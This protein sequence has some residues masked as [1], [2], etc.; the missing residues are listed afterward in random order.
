MEA[1]A[2]SPAAPPRAPGGGGMDRQDRLLKQLRAAR[3][4]IAR[5]QYR[6]A[7]RA[8]L[9]ALYILEEIM[10]SGE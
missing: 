9:A 10:M 7:Y 1:H 6:D 8:L 4:Y 3:Q 2:E 5:E